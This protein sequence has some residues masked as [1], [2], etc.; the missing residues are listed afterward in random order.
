MF[1]KVNSLLLTIGI[2][3]IWG[4]QNFHLSLA[5]SLIFCAIIDEVSKRR[6]VR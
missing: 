3:I 5:I 4:T 1:S 6:V 2:T